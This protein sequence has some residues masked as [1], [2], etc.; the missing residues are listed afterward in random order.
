VSTFSFPELEYDYEFVALR[1]CNEYPLNEGRVTSNRGM[2]ISA[3]D[4]EK[5]FQEEHVSYSN[6][7]QSRIIERGAYLV[8][9]MARYNLNFDKLPAIAQEAALKAG[10]GKECHNPFK[11]IVIRSVEMVF[12]CEEALRIIENYEKPEPPEAIVPKAGIGHGCT[13]AP[14]GILYHRYKIDENGMILEAKIVPPT[15][16]NQKMIEED[17]RNV[18]TAYADMPQDEL[19]WR[20]EQTVRNYDP[21]ISC[22]THFLRLDI[23]RS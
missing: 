23:D 14:R 16:Q 19:T 1:Q 12:A 9:P 15:S 2:S 10:L 4:Y 13:E 6:A 21:C 5:H 20:C 7:L 22:A 11:S 17:L 3:C 18:V 8:G